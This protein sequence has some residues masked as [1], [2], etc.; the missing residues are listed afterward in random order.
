MQPVYDLSRLHTTVKSRLHASLAA[1][2]QDIVHLRQDE[3]NSRV[4]DTI[5]TRQIVSNTPTLLKQRLRPRVYEKSYSLSAMFPSCIF[6]SVNFSSPVIMPDATSTEKTIMFGRD[7]LRHCAVTW[8]TA[9]CRVNVEPTKTA[10]NS[11]HRVITAKWSN[12]ELY[13]RNLLQTLA[14]TR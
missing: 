11:T 1:V 14:Y 8:M 3:T 10:L 4:V 9:R 5:S 12:A 7:V 13:S 6:R 2:Y